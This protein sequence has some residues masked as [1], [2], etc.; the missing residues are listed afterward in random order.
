MKSFIL[1]QDFDILNN[2]SFDSAENICDFN[3]FD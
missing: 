2:V 1:K 3:H